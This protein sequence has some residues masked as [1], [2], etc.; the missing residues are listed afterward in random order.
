VLIFDICGRTKAG[1]STTLRFAQ[2]DKSLLTYAIYKVGA[3]HKFVISTEAQR[4]GETCISIFRS[5]QYS[6]KD[7]STP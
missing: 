7:F 6:Q 3:F 2:D 1:L 4:S 5:C